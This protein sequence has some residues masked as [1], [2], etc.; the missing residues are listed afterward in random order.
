MLCPINMKQYSQQLVASPESSYPGSVTKSAYT[1]F[2]L[3]SLLVAWH[4][5]DLLCP[6]NSVS[7]KNMRFLIV[8]N[9]QRNITDH[10]VQ[11][12]LALWSCIVS[13][14]L[15]GTTFYCSVSLLLLKKPTCL[16]PNGQ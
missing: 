2:S 9:Q 14:A 16:A 7:N 1:S 12:L 5:R 4:C 8:M 3:E 15:C 6:A 11:F 13:A 10:Y